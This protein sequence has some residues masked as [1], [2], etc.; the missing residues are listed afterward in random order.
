MAGGVAHK[1]N[2]PLTVISNLLNEVLNNMPQD[3]TNHHKL[4]KVH[5]QL[6]KLN[7]ITKKIASVKKYE[8]IDYVAGVRIVDIDKAS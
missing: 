8:V 3:S 7:E 2:Q 1:L 6:E 4:E 5:K